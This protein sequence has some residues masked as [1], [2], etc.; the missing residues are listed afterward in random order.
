MLSWGLP[1]G[2]R[3]RAS[4]HQG[5]VP[6]GQGWIPSL[7]CLEPL[8]DTKRGVETAHPS[9]CKRERSSWL[10]T[11]ETEAFQ[12]FPLMEMGQVYSFFPMECHV[13]IDPSMSSRRYKRL[14]GVFLRY[15]NIKSR[16]ILRSTKTNDLLFTSKQKCSRAAFLSEH[17][18]RLSSE[19]KPYEI[20]H[21]LQ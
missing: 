12:A 17:R 1:R 8:G 21:S 3:L 11:A 13:I 14:A 5:Q 18:Q 2:A 16:L 15:A 9:P 19:K 7:Q 6:V 10:G 20:I 4:P